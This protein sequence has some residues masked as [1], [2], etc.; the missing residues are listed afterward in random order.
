MVYNIYI[1]YKH[2]S[3]KNI[4]CYPVFHTHREIEFLL[5]TGIRLNGDQVFDWF[6]LLENS[7]PTIDSSL[8]IVVLTYTFI[9][10]GQ[11]WLI[12]QIVTT[13]IL[14]TVNSCPPGFTVSQLLLLYYSFHSTLS[15]VLTRS[16]KWFCSGTQ[17]FYF[18]L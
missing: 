11:S 1:I 6:R 10:I 7:R 16:Y 12:I 4:F 9:R 14:T 17:F 8:Y 18:W 2:A 5:Y 15:T 13:T 3:N